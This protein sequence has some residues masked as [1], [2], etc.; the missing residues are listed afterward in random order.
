MPTVLTTIWWNK[1]RF[2]LYDEGIRL[3]CQDGYSSLCAWFISCMDEL[4]RVSTY[5]EIPIAV[6]VYYID[7]HLWMQFRG[8]KLNNIS[9]RTISNENK[10]LTSSCMSAILL[11]SIAFTIAEVAI[12]HQHEAQ[13]SNVICVTTEL[14]N[15]EKNPSCVARSCYSWNY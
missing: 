10:N 7:L 2:N 5:L 12:I 4:P 8:Q 13:I 11:H 1:T 14:H 3:Q 9:K 6:R 15:T